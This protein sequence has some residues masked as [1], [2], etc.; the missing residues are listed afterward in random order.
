MGDYIFNNKSD[1]VNYLF[2]KLDEPSPLKIQKTLYFLFAYYGAT[3]GNLSSEETGELD[4]I[5]YT[6]FLFNPAFEAWQYGPVDY[7][8]YTANREGCYQAKPLE[9][10]HLNQKLTPA[11]KRNVVQ[12][13]DNIISQTNEV[14]DFTLVDRTHE[15]EC[16]SKPFK[17]NSGAP[18]IKM[19]PDEIIEEY[20]TKHVG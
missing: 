17:E 5:N 1:L 15:D 18:H 11:E 4:S 6:K 19:N 12:F 7:E 9:M 10:E 16:W 20:I 8:V 14:D 2:E 3:Y 13:T